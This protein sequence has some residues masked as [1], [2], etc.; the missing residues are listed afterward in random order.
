MKPSEEASRSSSRDPARFRKTRFELFEEA[1]HNL[2]SLFFRVVNLV[3][4]LLF[5]KTKN[6]TG[7][8]T[9]KLID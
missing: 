6:N 1:S 2:Q 4:W 9:I 5:R 3:L 7:L 8:N